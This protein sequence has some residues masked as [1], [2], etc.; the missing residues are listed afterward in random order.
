[1]QQSGMG[2]WSKSLCRGTSR[3]ELIT[4]SSSGL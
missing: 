2:N 1:V 4:A 3:E